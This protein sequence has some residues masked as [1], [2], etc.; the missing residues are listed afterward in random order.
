MNVIALQTALRD[1]SPLISG[2]CTIPDYQRILYY[3]HGDLIRCIDFSNAGADDLEALY[4]ACKPAEFGRNGESVLD[5]S[6]RKAGKME[7]IS[8]ST[9]LDP[10]SLGIHEQVSKALLTRCHGTMDAELYKLNV[11][12]KVDFFK[13]HKDTPRNKNMFGSLVVLLPT[14]HEGGQ[15]VL[16]QGEK[17]WTLDLASELAIATKP[18]VYFVAFYGDLEHEVL[19]VTSGYRVTLTYNLYHKP[20]QP[21]TSSIFTPLHRKLKQALVDLVNDKTK[22]PNGGYL[23]F[24]LIHEYVH[25]GHNLLQLLLGQLKGSDRALADVCDEL[26]LRYSLRLLYREIT[27][28][29]VNFITTMELDVEDWGTEVDYSEY[30]EEALKEFTID[31]AEGITFVGGRSPFEPEILEEGNEYEYGPWLRAFYRTPVTEVLEITRMKSSV[32]HATTFT[33]HTGNEPM[34]TCF[35]GTACMLVAVEPAASRE[36]VGL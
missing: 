13:A 12:G 35:Y 9:L 21:S 18:S 31:Q 10:H 6:Y 24:G 34:S 19:P 8:F 30:L 7:P 22:L 2:L 11:Y 20:I 33:V 36:V 25:T 23:G 17:E 28:P 4:R 3:R 27:E 16:R 32:D 1:R 26:G 29:F 15:F 5:E 14:A